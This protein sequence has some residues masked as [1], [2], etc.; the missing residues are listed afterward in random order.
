MFE[1]RK[2]LIATK[3][4]KEKVISKHFT[5]ELGVLCEVPDNYNTDQFGTFTGEKERKLSPIDT[6]KEKC[7]AAMKKY[8]FDLGVASEGSFGPHP[9][10][11]FIPA[12]E[13]FMIFI[14]KRNDI[15]IVVKNLS[16][17]TNFS[18]RIIKNDQELLK[19]LNAIKYPSHGVILR[20]KQNS[21]E[22]TIKDIRTLKSL[23]KHTKD[24]V[25]KNGE[26]YIETDMRAMNNPTRMKVIEDTA[27]KLIKAI[28]S[29]CPNC[30]L[31][32]FVPIKFISGL[33]CILCGLPTKSIKSEILGCKK[34]GFEIENLFPKNKRNEDP[35]FCDYC[36]P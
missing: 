34:C 11:Y 12:D 2:L 25:D 35:Q 6:V 26:V 5:K 19:Y 23:K 22:H 21:N 7:L 17:D 14:D 18:G 33:P 32:G 20:K 27:I 4:K 29:K 13:E 3:H 9:A 30:Q 36:N 1:G 28:Q 10:I 16:T 31:P 15:E 8:G 24:L